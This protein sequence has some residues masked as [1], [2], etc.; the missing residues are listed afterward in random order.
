MK[1]RLLDI[2]TEEEGSIETYTLLYVKQS[3][4]D[5]GNPKPVLCD[6]LE[7]EGWEGGGFP[8]KSQVEESGSEGE[9]VHGREAQT[10]ITVFKC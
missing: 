4:Y 6:N 7:G 5:A 2:A 10:R 8:V 9:K 1:N 3:I